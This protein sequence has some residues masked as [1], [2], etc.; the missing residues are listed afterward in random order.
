MA[1]MHH[2][3]AAHRSKAIAS[4]NLEAN[5]SWLAF[6]QVIG[7]RVHYRRSALPAACAIR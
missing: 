6:L 4:D 1:V 3:G 2:W 7:Y 5:P